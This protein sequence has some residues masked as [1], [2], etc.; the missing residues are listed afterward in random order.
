MKLEPIVI[1]KCQ[2]ITSDAEQTADSADDSEHSY[3]KRSTKL[4]SES[5]VSGEA[6]EPEPMNQHVE[7]KSK[8]EPIV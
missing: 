6:I 5:F 7:F 8:P 1:W 2:L 4:S 3:P